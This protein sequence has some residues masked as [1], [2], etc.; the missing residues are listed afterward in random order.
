M[1]AFIVLAV[2]WVARVIGRPIIRRRVKAVLADHLETTE[3]VAWL[4]SMK[5]PS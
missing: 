4:R 1:T 5:E 2:V 3:T